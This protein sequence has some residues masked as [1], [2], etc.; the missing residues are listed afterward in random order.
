MSDEYMEAVA[1]CWK[2]IERVIATLDEEYVVIVMADHGGH[3][4]MHGTQMP[5][6]MTIPMFFRGKSFEKGKE[7]SGITLLDIAPTVAR[8]M[9]FPCEKEWDGKAI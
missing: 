3:D 4:R 6:D 7:L 2:N 9:D 8:I 1:N 5:E